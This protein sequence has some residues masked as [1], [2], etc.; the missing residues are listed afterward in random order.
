MKLKKLLWAAPLAVLATLDVAHADLVAIRVGLAETATEDGSIEHAV[1]LVEDGKIVTIGQDLPIGRGIPVIDRPD[2]VVMPGLVSA[3]SRLGLDSQAGDDFTPHVTAEKELL[4]RNR[5]YEEAL[6]HGV[7]TLGLYPAGS[8]VPGQ[9]LVVRPK[10]D[11]K[12]EMILASGA[13]LKMRF[14]SNSRSKKTL[15]E[16]FEKVDEYAEEL[17]EEREKYDKKVERA[18]KK[19]KRKKKDDEDENDDE[20]EIGPFEPPE[21]APEVEAFQQ[22]RARTLQMLFSIGK[23][24]DYLHL[25]KAIDDEEFDWGLRVRS[26]SQLDIFHVK[27]EIGEAERYVLIDP[28]LTL[29]PGTSRQR[30]LPDELAEE[31]ARLVL[32]PRS[33]SNWGFDR[34]LRDVG[35]L[36]ATGL[37][38]ETAIAAM[39][40]TAAEFLGVGERLGSLAEGKDAN[41]IFLNGD[42][43][44]PGTQIEAVMLEGEFVHGEVQQ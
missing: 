13:Y 12:D 26:T 2:W 17:A 32:L 6:E 35:L 28:Q 37:D 14:N 18:E 30:N 22:V 8:G 11:E 24:A 15:R 5:A 21:L 43:F 39:T 34:W 25:V 23:S 42:P 10:G 4:P 36:V 3:Y 9:A 16:A 20:E 44:E 1:V 40:S 31:G 38:R 7:T 33:D 19:K 41:L 29:H 27:E